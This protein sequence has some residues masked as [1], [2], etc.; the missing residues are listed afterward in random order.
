MQCSTIVSFFIVLYNLWDLFPSYIFHLETLFGNVHSNLE[1]RPSFQIV[2]IFY[3][4]LDILLLKYYLF[5]NMVVNGRTTE[6][7]SG[8]STV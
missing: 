8:T 7:S 3:T 1:S 4:F 6:R 2:L 5:F